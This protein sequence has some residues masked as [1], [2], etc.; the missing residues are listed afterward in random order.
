MPDYTLEADEDLQESPGDFR[1]RIEDSNRK[2]REAE[3]RAAAAERELAFA[4]AGLPLDDPKMS[5]FVKGYEGEVTPEAI[6][7]AAEQ[8]GF[9]SN[10][11]APEPQVPAQEL[12][13][14][15]AAAQLVAGAQTD[16]AWA[17]LVHENPQYQ[18]EMRSARSQ[19]DVLAI[20]AKYGSPIL[21]DI[22]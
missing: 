16:T 9:L 1:R 5:Y 20:M 10:Q 7:A 6:R 3:D 14:H 15:Q 13:A 8:A 2:A 12:A 21:D 4:K 22:D 11:T 18:A 19:D 17:G